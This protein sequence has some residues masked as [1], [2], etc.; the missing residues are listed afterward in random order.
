MRNILLTLAI[1]AC[2]C[3]P[4]MAGRNANGAMVVHTNDSVNYT[5][6]AKY[7]DNV[8]SRFRRHAKL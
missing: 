5:S 4:A 1:L 2:I 3:S 8:H 7:C 6:T